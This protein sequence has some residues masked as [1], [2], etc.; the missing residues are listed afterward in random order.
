MD[1]Q[2]PCCNSFLVGDVTIDMSADG[3]LC[4]EASSGV[5]NCRHVYPYS[6]VDVATRQWGEVPAIWRLKNMG[7]LNV[8]MAIVGACMCG[9]HKSR[10]IAWA[11]AGLDWAGFGDGGEESDGQLS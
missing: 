6:D 7:R 5:T 3:S 9:Y 2:L 8:S 11:L 4:K 1:S 10:H